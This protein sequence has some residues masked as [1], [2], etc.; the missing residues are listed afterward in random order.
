MDL[1]LHKISGKD[2]E[3][4]KYKLREFKLYKK[5]QVILIKDNELILAH[6]IHLKQSLYNL[7]INSNFEQIVQLLIKKNYHSISFD[8]DHLDKTVL[9][10]CLAHNYN[11]P[12]FITE[13]D[14]Q[15]PV[16]NILYKQKQDPITINY[17]DYMIKEYSKG[18]TTPC[19]AHACIEKSS[20]QQ[21]YSSIQNETSGEISG[22]LKITQAVDELNK[23]IF[24]VSID[25]IKKGNEDDAELV[26]SRYNFHTHPVNA[27]TKY[28]CDLGWPSKDDYVI[29]ATSA[30]D[31][32]KPT[33]F[34]LVCTKEGIYVLSIPKESIQYIVTLRE[35]DRDLEELFED[36]VNEHLEIDKLNFK[37]EKGVKTNDNKFINSVSSYIR[38]INNRPLFT[39]N[40]NNEDVSFRLIK[41][42]FLNWTGPLGILESPVHR[43][44]FTYHYPKIG[45]NCIMN[46]EHIRK[47]PKQRTRQRKKR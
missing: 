2:I 8:F 28:N 9:S 4:E 46:E 19:E 14:I 10:T 39:I 6:A 27:Y 25:N 16:L 13:S 43:V 15:L 47:G 5:H 45:G 11:N 32:R 23:I 37:I 22:K 3:L 36:Y 40:I 44:Y 34:H 30:V 35:D 31:N 24:E 18:L 38:Y 20:L 41:V 1:K 12:Y 26:E 17:I 21:I 42:D 7:V 29:F 33:I